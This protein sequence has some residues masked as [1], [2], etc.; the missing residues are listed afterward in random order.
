MMHGVQMTTTVATNWLLEK[1]KA[2][3]ETH[4]TCF[5]EARGG[6]IEAAERQ[7]GLKLVL[8]AEGEMTS[9]SFNLYV[10]TDHTKEYETLIGMLEASVHEEVTLS[11]AEYNM[12]VEDEWDWTDSWLASNAGYSMST[13]V[14]AQAKGLL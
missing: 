5:D 2:N 13:R 10:P 8:L 4:K 14:L 6:Y 9:L 1:L 11:F 12:Y 3:K 7:L